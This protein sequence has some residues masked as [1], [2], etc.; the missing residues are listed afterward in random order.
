MRTFSRNSWLFILLL[1]L[2]ALLLVTIFVYYP[3][4]TTFI[5]SFTNKNLRI[6]GADDFVGIKNY[7]TLLSKPEFWQVTGRSL[8][9]VA[10]TLPLEILI[11]FAIALLLNENFPGRGIVRALVILPWM[12]P[13][14]VN[15]FLWN[16]LLNGE[17]GA[18]NGLLYQFGLIDNYVFWLQKPEAQ[19]L[20]TVIVQTWTRFAF[21]MII[22]LAGLQSIPGELLEAAAIDGAG[23]MKRLLHVTVPMLFPSLAV[24]LMV[25]FISSFQIF[26]IVWTLTAGG[27]VGQVINPYTKTLMIY[28]YQLVFRDMK[29]GAGS[30][31]SYLILMM[32]MVVGVYILRN[33]YNRGEEK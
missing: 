24:A 5:S 32:S 3:S 6:P 2:P 26:D 16:W 31:L 21:P 18:L 7:V 15:G 9:L 30:A 19:I 22:L 25:E 20:W 28:N 10:L 33:L 14:V 1:L 12:L 27:N 23:W 29:I 8:L 13:P 4:V 17:F 11:G